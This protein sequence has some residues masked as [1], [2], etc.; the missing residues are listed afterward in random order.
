MSSILVE[1]IKFL[2]ISIHS[3][4]P[5]FE[6]QQLSHLPFHKSSGDVMV[7]ES[8]LELIPS[9]LVASRLHGLEVL[10]PQQGFT[11][12]LQGCKTGLALL[13]AW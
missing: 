3:V 8:S 11:V 2:C 13:G 12:E 6:S 1:I 10:P 7:L 9:E 5:L 4:R